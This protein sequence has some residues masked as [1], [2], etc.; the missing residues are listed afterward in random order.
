[1]QQLAYLVIID[2]YPCILCILY[3]VYNIIVMD[4]FLILGFIVLEYEA[5]LDDFFLLHPCNFH[6]RHF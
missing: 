1:M 4:G 6:G 3:I 2:V 5:R